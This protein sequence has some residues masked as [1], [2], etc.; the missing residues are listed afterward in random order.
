MV[1]TDRKSMARNS[2]MKDR[3]HNEKNYE[4]QLKTKFN[5]NNKTIQSRYKF[6]LSNIQR[7]ISPMLTEDKYSNEKLK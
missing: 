2:S 6:I 1:I 5:K 3:E 4:T 7:L